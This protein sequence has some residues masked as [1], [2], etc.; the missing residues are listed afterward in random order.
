M[1]RQFIYHMAGLTKAYGNKKVLENIHLHIEA[2][3]LSLATPNLLAN[4][5]D[6]PEDRGDC[7]G[8]LVFYSVSD[9]SIDIALVEGMRI[10]EARVL[11]V[12]DRLKLEVDLNEGGGRQSQGVS[13][14]S[15]EFGELRLEG[16][17]LEHGLLA[18][19]LERMT[20]SS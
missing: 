6:L 16:F 18:K 5:S 17:D 11:Q 9:L 10:A 7:P 3:A 2:R 4:F 1:A 20:H 19:L 8:K 13:S 12:G 15:F 14:I